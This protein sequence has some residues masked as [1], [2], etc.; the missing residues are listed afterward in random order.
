MQVNKLQATFFALLAALLYA[1]N[2][3]FSKLLLSEVSPV[4]MASFLYL[5]AGIGIGILYAL[6]GSKKQ[7]RQALSK[8][9]LPFT[10]GMIVLDILAP[11]F[12]MIGLQT[13]S[14]ASASLLNNFEIV[15]TTV[16]ALVVFRELVSKRLWVAIVLIIV[17]SILLTV[18]DFSSLSFSIGSL[19]VILA[20]ICWGFEN[21]CTRMLAS[22]NTYEI[23]FLKGIFSGL[24]SFVVAFLVGETL[25]HVAYILLTLLL[26]FVAYGLSI[27]FYIQAQDVLGASKTSAY[28]ATAP[29][30]GTFLSFVIFRTAIS[31][32]Y[33]VSLVIMIFGT[34]L[35]V[36]DT[37][38]VQHAH[39]H[40][41][42]KRN[43]HGKCKTYTHSHAHSHNTAH[44]LQA[45]H[46][47]HHLHIS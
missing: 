2:M 32:S 46:A 16:I 34:I 35:V 11:I 12:L 1:I 37:F 7:A 21:N 23:V 6:L 36:V 31:A 43:H 20:C 8:S 9:D 25:P 45:Q 33:L 10:L 18:E 41:H 22:K 3:P 17:S 15:A 39:V 44:D 47:H 27:F 38:A 5:G 30:I 13:A 26:G 19:F 4:F 42:S 29:F 24:G 28:Y 14:S 40:T